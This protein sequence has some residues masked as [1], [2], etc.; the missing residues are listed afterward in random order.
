MV[1]LGGEQKK[2]AEGR[3][4]KKLAL[5]KFLELQLL[6]AEAPESV[7]TRVASVCDAFL[8][9]SQRHQSP[10]TYRGYSFYAQSFSEACG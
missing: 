2:L 3:G 9:W 1:T 7:H 4:N 8:Q 5:K 6:V 10:E